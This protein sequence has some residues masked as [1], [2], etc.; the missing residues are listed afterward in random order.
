MKILALVLTPYFK[1][2]ILTNQIKSFYLYKKG[3]DKIVNMQ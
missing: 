3:Y 1:I 2:I